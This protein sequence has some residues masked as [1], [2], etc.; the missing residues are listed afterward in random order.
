MTVSEN[1]NPR[2]PYGARQA[3]CT[4]DSARCRHFN[5]RAPYGARHAVTLDDL[6]CR[7]ISIHAP[8][9]GRDPDREV[10]FM[11]KNEF[12]STR[13]IRGATGPSNDTPIKL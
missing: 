6:L 12:Q 9:T 5:P 13:P 1:F 10:I 7:D 4:P 3:Q 8:H 2:A 11:P